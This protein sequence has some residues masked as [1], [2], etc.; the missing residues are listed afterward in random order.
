MS[1]E[2]WMI[3][4]QRGQFSPVL[5]DAQSISLVKDGEDLSTLRF[6]YSHAW[7]DVGIGTTDDGQRIMLQGTDDQD[8]EIQ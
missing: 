5:I 8:D 1:E 2:V 4:V 7:E 3:D 6:R